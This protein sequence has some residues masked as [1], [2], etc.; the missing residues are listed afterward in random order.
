MKDNLSREERQLL[1]SIK[2][3]DDVIY[4][5]ED[6]GPSF[7]KMTKDLY[8]KAGGDELGKEKFHQEVTQHSGRDIKRKNDMI[9]YEMIN[10]N[11]IS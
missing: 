3:N 9:V 2:E 7:V 4:I 10:K 8:L 1:K 6:K 5:W 11:D